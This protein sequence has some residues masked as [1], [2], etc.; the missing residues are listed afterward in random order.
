VLNLGFHRI[1]VFI[2]RSLEFTV[3]HF[4]L[5]TIV[6]AY[7]KAGCPPTGIWVAEVE[8]GRNYQPMVVT[9][10]AMG[11]YITTSYPSI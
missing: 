1:R 5:R 11:Y 4:W 2:Y 9:G 6:E 10:S 3:Q 7:K 8:N